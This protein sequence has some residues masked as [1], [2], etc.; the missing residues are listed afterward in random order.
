MKSMFRFLIPLIAFLSFVKSSSD[1]DTIPNI[2][3]VGIYVTCR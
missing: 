1:Q 3:N 2:V